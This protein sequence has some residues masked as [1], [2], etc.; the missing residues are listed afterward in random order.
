[1]ENNSMPKQQDHFNK[2]LEKGLFFVAVKLLL[3]EG[4]KLLLLH[5]IFD[6]WDLPGGRI[7]PHEFGN[8]L[9][10]VI[11]RKMTE[12]VGPDVRFKLGD[13]KV[14]FQVE[15]DETG[16]EQKA[17]IFAVGFESDYLG[18]EIKLGEHHDKFLW[19]DVH[20][21][22]P[23]DYLSNGWETGVEAYLNQLK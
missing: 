3:R 4:D 8:P 23:A 14:F 5:D 9:E 7:K 6:S 19:V 10:E 21:L 17:R 1:M 22:S 16:L 11:K 18:G 13:P 20:K 15:R 12:E 2:S